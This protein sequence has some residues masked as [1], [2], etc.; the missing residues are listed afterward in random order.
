MI[1]LLARL[2]VRGASVLWALIVDLADSPFPS[3]GCHDAN[4]LARWDDVL[5]D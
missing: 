4:M 5:R 3:R 1:T 2:V